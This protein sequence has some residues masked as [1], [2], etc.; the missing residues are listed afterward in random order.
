[1]NF[2]WPRQLQPCLGQWFRTM[3]LDCLEVRSNQHGPQLRTAA[4]SR[5]LYGLIQQ[6]RLDQRNSRA[7]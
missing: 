4:S 6:T 7:M 5:S 3:L 1:M 2:L